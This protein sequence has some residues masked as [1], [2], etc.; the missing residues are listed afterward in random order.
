MLQHFQLTVPM[1]RRERIAGWIGGISALALAA[2]LLWIVFRRGGAIWLLPAA[3]GL[4]NAGIRA[5]FG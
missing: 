2:V 5:I 4:S 1:T 3:I